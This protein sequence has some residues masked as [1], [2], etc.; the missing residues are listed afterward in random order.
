MKNSTLRL[1]F[2]KTFVFLDLN[3]VGTRHPSISIFCSVCS[4]V[5]VCVFVH[6]VVVVV[7]GGGAAV[8]VVLVGGGGAAA[9]SAA[10]V[11]VFAVAVAAAV[12][13]VEFDSAVTR[14]GTLSGT[15]LHIHMCA[16][17]VFFFQS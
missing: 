3:G 7:V 5:C 9:V 6:V 15:A 16:E 13:S 14:T 2:V 17:P 12:A 10:I 11:V 1:F 8:V 4:C